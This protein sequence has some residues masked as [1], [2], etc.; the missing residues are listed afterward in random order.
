MSYGFE[1]RDANGRTSL[2]LE[3]SL[4]RIVHAQRFEPGYS[5][6]FTVP[7]FS[8]NTGMFY[9]TPCISKR[10]LYF[11]KLADNTPLNSIVGG[12][13]FT[14][15]AYG[16]PELTWTELTKTMTITPYTLPTN[17][18]NTNAF[19]SIYCGNSTNNPDYW[20]VFLKTNLR[21]EVT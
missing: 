14:A 9:Y 5:G 8:I 16:Q 2:K 10:T 18:P 21:F 11:T 20:V 15:N 7:D 19:G 6:S 17:W 4:P 13:F 12:H 3:E 1:F